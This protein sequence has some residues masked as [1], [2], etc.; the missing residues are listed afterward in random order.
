MLYVIVGGG[1]E[2]EGKRNV[3]VEK[4][5]DWL[6]T[7][8]SFLATYIIVIF[9]W[10][11][12]VQHKTCWNVY[13]E[14]CIVVRWTIQSVKRS[15]DEWTRLIWRD[16]VGETSVKLW[17]QGVTRF[18]DGNFGHTRGHGQR[19]RGSVFFGWRQREKESN[20]VREITM[21]EANDICECIKYKKYKKA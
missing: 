17:T 10:E 3:H 7:D 5:R 6:A 4:K 12:S 1:K 14:E 13:C 11:S 19:S 15:G 21:R 2:E 9:A 8:I 18:P 20:T 16:D